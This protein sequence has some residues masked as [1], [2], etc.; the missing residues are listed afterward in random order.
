MPQDLRPR[1]PRVEQGPPVHLTRQAPESCGS[2][3]AKE[4]AIDSPR[5]GNPAITNDLYRANAPALKSLPWAP[6]GSTPRSVG[7]EEAL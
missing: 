2:S 7:R 4:G 6:A 3:R 5:R 1:E